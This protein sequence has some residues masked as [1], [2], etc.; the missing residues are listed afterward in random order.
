MVRRGEINKILVSYTPNLF[1]SSRF[2]PL[3]SYLVNRPVNFKNSKYFIIIMTVK[4]VLNILNSL[5]NPYKSYD[6]NL[7]FFYIDELEKKSTNS[8]SG[9]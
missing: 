9:F 1:I 8:F 5:L 6:Y 3:C 4:K 2:N 7:T